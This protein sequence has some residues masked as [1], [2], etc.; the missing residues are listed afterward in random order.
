MRWLA[1][2]SPTHCFRH[3]EW[4]CMVPAKA[5]S[6]FPAFVFH[7]AVFLAHWGKKSVQ[8]WDSEP[9]LGK[10]PFSLGKTLPCLCASTEVLCSACDT[11][12]G[13]SFS[14]Q[15]APSAAA[16]A[17]GFCDAASADPPRTCSLMIRMA[18]QIHATT[19]KQGQILLVGPCPLF[20]G[21]VSPSLCRRFWCLS[22]CLAYL[23]RRQQRAA[24]V[25]FVSQMLRAATL[26]VGT[27]WDFRK[28]S[29]KMN[30]E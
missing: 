13:V 9:C 24:L 29:V 30:L 25:T 16:A 17:P 20:W 8:H 6:I 15:P 22:L 18:A 26:I 4:S 7:I 14:P 27:N 2:L 21:F 28:E 1:R 19:R 5:R 11:H 10:G 12:P 3:L 23:T